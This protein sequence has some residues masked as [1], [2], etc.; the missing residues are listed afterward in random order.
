MSNNGKIKAGRIKGGLMQ[1]VTLVVQERS[2][3]DKIAI[4][5]RASP[6][7]RQ[8]VV[9]RLLLAKYQ[10]LIRLTLSCSRS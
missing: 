1:A 2:S 6:L 3:R 9:G 10:Q 4:M 5:S 8:H 7:E